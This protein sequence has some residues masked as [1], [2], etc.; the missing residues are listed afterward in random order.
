M[1][2]TAGTPQ[3]SVILVCYNSSQWLTK[4]L[5][6]LRKQS[7]FDQTELIVVDNASADG[8]ENL[9]R[10]LTEGWPNVRILQTGCN[11]GFSANNRG[12]EI[13]RGKYLYLLN[14]DT[15]LEPDCLEQL[16]RAVD[17]EHADSAGSTVL[18]YEDQT[19]QAKGSHGFDVFGNP[20]SPR[21]DRDPN[22]LFC[23][24]GFYFI[25]R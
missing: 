2:Q 7:I 25:N 14:P 17:K 22:R 11:L 10:R 12:A 16:Y 24:A 23:I 18:E 20:V 1:N 19:L 21:A 8:S 13:A 15:W 4:C 3:V 5:E 9:A 6:S